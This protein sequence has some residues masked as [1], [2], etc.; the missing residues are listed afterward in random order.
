MERIKTYKAS[1]MDLMRIVSDITNS[2]KLVDDTLS[3]ISNNK[4]ILDSDEY[5]TIKDEFPELKPGFMNMMVMETKYSINIKKSLLI[6]VMLILDV[7]A[8]KGVSSAILS[9]S[10]YPSRT[11]YKIE[12]NERCILLDTLIGER[13]TANDY[14]YNENE[15][16]QNDIACLYRKNGV[17]KRT[18]ENIDKTIDILLSKEIL[19]FKNNQYK[20]S[21]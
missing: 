2:G 21:F 6:L 5:I 9:M 8:T 1:K 15:C 12:E 13:K 11:I 16:V 10:G 19:I 3:F 20:I 4:K 14:L 17:C 18:I 7:K